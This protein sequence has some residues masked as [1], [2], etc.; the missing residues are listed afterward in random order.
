MGTTLCWA[1]TFFLALR[2]EERE[3]R[4][5]TSL[6]LVMAESWF[7]DWISVAPVGDLP[8]LDPLALWVC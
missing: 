5:Q 6:L 8:G 1:F 2:A 7:V 4:L 3:P